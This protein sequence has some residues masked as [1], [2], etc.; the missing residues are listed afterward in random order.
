MPASEYGPKH[1]V[2]CSTGKIEF[3]PLTTEE[4]AQRDR[5]R[6]DNEALMNAPPPKTE[7]ELLKDQIAALV[8]RVADLEKKGK[9]TS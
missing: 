2:D 8:Q 9:K 4:V 7:T 5:E 6:A 3:I 1:V